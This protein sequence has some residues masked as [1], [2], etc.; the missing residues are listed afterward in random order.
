[1]PTTEAV[2]AVGTIPLVI[3]GE[4]VAGEDGTYPVVQPGPARPRWSCT[5]RRASADQL[6]GA[7]AAA[8]GAQPGVG[9]PSP[10]RAGSSCHGRR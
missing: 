4:A 9:A 1:M 8:R 5:P 2:A 3:D 7:V 6:D 10:R